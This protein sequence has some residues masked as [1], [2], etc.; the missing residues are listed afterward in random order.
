MRALF[1]KKAGKLKVSKVGHGRQEKGM[2]GHSGVQS[3]VPSLGSCLTTLGLK[4]FI[5]DLEISR[6]LSTYHVPAALHNSREN[7]SMNTAENPIIKVIT[8]VTPA[9]RRRHQMLAQTCTHTTTIISLICER[10]LCV[11]QYFSLLS[12]GP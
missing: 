4:L 3:A 2:C 10:V 11:S 1:T 5:F 7:S 8:R 12:R 9:S 6:V